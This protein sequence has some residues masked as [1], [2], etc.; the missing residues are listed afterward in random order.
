MLFQ[1]VHTHNG[2]NCPAG[3]A[4]KTKNISDW[5]Q[6]LKKTPGIKILSANVSPLEHAFY[7]TVE[8]DDFQVLSKTL[9]FLMS[10]GTG[11]VS[12][13]LTLDQSIPIA[14]AG[15]YRSLK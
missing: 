7:I 5:W 1:V 14:E 2:E 9:G 4:E 15:A 12:P 3:S 8:V 13:I 6:A 10:F 11:H